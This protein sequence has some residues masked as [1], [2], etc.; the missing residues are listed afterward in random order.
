MK[1]TMILGTLAAVLLGTVMLA[2]TTGL[3]AD[4]TADSGS[5]VTLTWPQFV[6]ITGYD[7]LKKGGQT[8]SVPWP[9]V[10]K[11]IGVVV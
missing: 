2:A 10:Q 7:P 5:K 4:A 11:L 9:D 8:L 3:A 6:K 1:R